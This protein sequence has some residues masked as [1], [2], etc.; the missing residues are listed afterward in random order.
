MDKPVNAV[1][2]DALFQLAL[3][4]GKLQEMKAE[5]ETL[6]QVF[7]ENEELSRILTH[8]DLD[9]NAKVNLMENIFKEKCSDNMMGF[10]S[11][12]VKKGRY[13]E[14]ISIFDYF[15]R[16]AKEEEGIGTASVASAVN[17][18]EKAKKRIE[19]RLLELTKYKSL[20]MTYTVDESLIAGLVIRIG[21]RVA[22][23][24]MKTKLQNMKKVLTKAQLT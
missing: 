21:G 13:E 11:L 2:G 24:S 12:T 4:E 8:P 23:S 5:V 19:D 20:E 16:R 3:E 17:L 18:T 14:I 22:D 7:I 1:Y 15:I 6:R 10:L 9:K